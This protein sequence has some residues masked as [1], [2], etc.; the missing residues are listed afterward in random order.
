MKGIF[1]K[2][3]GMMQVFDE[4]GRRVPL[5][6][7]KATPGVVVR[8]KT[9]ET[10]GYGA[11]QVGFNSCDLK[12]LNRPEAGVYKKTLQTKVGYRDLKEFK[13]DNP[14][15]YKVGQEIKVDQFAAGDKVDVRSRSIGKGF[16]GTIK[17]YHFGRGPMTHGS[18]NKR[19]PGSIGMSAT[20]S[21]VHKGKKLP[22]HM[23]SVNRTVQRITV[24]KVDEEKNLLFLIGGIPGSRNA[25]VMIHETAKKKKLAG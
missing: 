4:S 5:S 13:V 21:R 23:G 6:V 10:D 15:D 14:N 20:P 19:E 8:V 2:K 16:A 17:R 22:G 11:I 24:Y 18:K 1:G 12:K 9:V 7:V 25:N 3:L